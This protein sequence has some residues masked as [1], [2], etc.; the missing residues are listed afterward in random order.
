MIR[1]G[2]LCNYSNRRIL[3]LRPLS[4]I[5]RYASNHQSRKLRGPT[6]QDVSYF[7]SILSRPDRSVLDGSS[8]ST[9]SQDVTDEIAK[10]NVD[11]TKKYRG[12]SDL[13]LRPQTT[14]E[15]S[16]ILQYCHE[17]YIGITPQGGNTG[18]CGGATPYN[19]EIILSMEDMDRIY[20]ID[21]YSGILT[22]DAGCILQNLHSYAEENG[23]LFPL[24]IGS[25]GSCQIGGNVSTNAGGHH[26]FRFG[27]LHGTVVGME[28]VLANG[29]VLRSSAS[30]RK[31]NTGYDLKQLFI[32]AEGTLGIVTKVA[33]ACPALPTSKN[34]VLLVCNSYD[35]VLSV[36]QTAKEELGEIL[37]AIE[38]IDWNTMQF[39]QRFGNGFG[40]SLISELLTPKS[41]SSD[42][43]KKQ[44]PLYI[45]V[46]SQGCDQVSD[47]A[48]MDSFLTSL[49]E[50]SAIENGVL[51]HD[52]KQMEEI[53]AIRESCNP[54]VAS[55]GFV[56]KFDVSI[57]IEMYIEVSEEVEKHLQDENL[58]D[59]SV[60]T[61][62]HVADGN[63]HINIV[64][65]GQFHKHDDT[66]EKIE[67]IV[68]SS[69]MKRK[70]S[71]SAE[72]G[73]G[74]SKRKYL[75]QIKD[76]G[77]LELMSQ[78]KMTFDPHLILNP[79]KYIP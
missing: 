75:K 67:N 6:T 19:T 60:C 76:D 3:P 70:G 9:A 25:K 74:Q 18:L 58:H 35:D 50:S 30:V 1:L 44:S 7:R 61:W 64:S 46:E 5:L 28:V 43:A 63:A 78:I 69:V 41:I 26:F 33:I 13:V 54:S 8:S 68:Y 10:Y 2:R 36:L 29:R 32:G 12:S 77:V 38:L 66:A 45:L 37:S 65:S 79:G 21:E 15:V 16:S 11:W 59:L 48:K 55:A 51:A 49:Y 56:H 42:P 20:C 52:S 53:W 4:S 71:I 62:G 24:D 40:S 17:N 27:S 72:H 23:F 73:I 39:V 31:D 22:C 14:S 34:V 57:P 47:S